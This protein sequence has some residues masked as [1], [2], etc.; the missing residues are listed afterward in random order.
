MGR[1]RDDMSNISVRHVAPS[2]CRTTRGSVQRW[3]A[4]TTII[5]NY[6]RVTK[7]QN[8]WDHR[9]GSRTVCPG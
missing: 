5:R 6:A 3:L 2:V 4:W 9:G 7:A 8:G 1:I